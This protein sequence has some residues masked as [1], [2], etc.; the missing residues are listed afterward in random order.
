M[1]REGGWGG[2]HPFR[3]LG[4][5]LLSITCHD[6][7]TAADQHF[8]WIEAGL[9]GLLGSRPCTTTGPGC[10]L[11]ELL[12]GAKNNQTTC[13]QQRLG[14]TPTR[15][16]WQDLHEVDLPAWLDV[17][18]AGPR[19]K[20]DRCLQ[21]VLLDSAGSQRKRG[22]AWLLLISLSLQSLLC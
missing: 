10:I 14:C 7:S 19:G 3:L 22:R 16:L 4:I 15:Q 1:G 6:S 17:H 8:G 20:K 21:L 5:P 2:T 12:Q 13:S 11:R 9:P 18:H